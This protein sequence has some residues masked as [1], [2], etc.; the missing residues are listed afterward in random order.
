LGGKVRRFLVPKS[1]AD[2]EISG[3]EVEVEVDTDSNRI[4]FAI[5]EDG[6]VAVSK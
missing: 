2:P 1:L 5:A 6:S 4:D 3:I